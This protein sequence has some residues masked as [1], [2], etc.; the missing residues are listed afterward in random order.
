MMLRSC[1]VGLALVL[2]TGSTAVAQ[3][4]APPPAPS[5]QPPTPSPTPRP[6]EPAAPQTPAEPPRFEDTVVVTAS[7]VEEK[8]VNVAP[9]M[10]VINGDTIQNSVSRSYADLLRLVPGVNV[11]QTAARDISVTS[12]SATGTLATSQLALLDGRTI[13]QDFFGFVMWDF[14]PISLDEIKQIEVI[15]G[16]ASATWGAN[17]LTGVVNVISKS[18][19]ELKGTTVDMRFG[20]FDRSVPGLDQKAGALFSINGT[21][22]DVINDRWAYKI[23]AGGVTQQA[24]PRPTGTI[25]NAFAT[26]YPAYANQGTTQ[27]KFDARVDHDLSGN[28]QL[29][30]AGGVAGTRG[31]IHT[32]IGPFDIQSGS[33]LGYG[34]VNY[35]RGPLKINFF[36][37][38]LDGDADGLL[39]LDTRGQP[40]LFKFKNQ[41][42]DLEFGNVQTVGTRHVINYGGNVRHNTFDLSIAPRGTSRNEG[43]AYAQDEIVLSDHL[44]WIVGGRVDRFDVLSNAV[45][46]PRTTL[47]LKVTPHHTVRVSY[48]R[49][50]RAPSLVNN[51]IDVGI[52]NQIDL[53]LINPALAG[54]N[55]VFPTQAVGNDQLKEESLPA[56]EIGYT[57]VFPRRTIVSAAFYVNDTKNEILFKQIGSYTSAAPA[58]G[59]PLPPSVLDLLVAGNAFGPGAGLPS[60]FSY[61]NFGTIRDKGIELGVESAMHPSTSVFVNY[62]FQAKPVPTGFDISDLNLPPQNRFNAGANF[63]RGHYL[64]NVSVSF[65]DGAFWQD[66]LDARFHGPTDSYT[67]VNGGFGV[68]WNSGKLTTSVGVTNLLNQNVQQHVFGDVLKRQVVGQLRVRF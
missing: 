33:V 60:L 10:T 43:G 66:V 55:Y 57:G 21:H 5:S 54:H 52:L 61:R 25:N 51:F 40:L 3:T 17:A 41:T 59:W 67:L 64:G 13:Y 47:L 49:G 18:P 19:R 45:F 27:P 1:G 36:V 4:P 8:L 42:Y 32:G 34:K 62:S 15:R 23:S 39:S 26:P 24:L 16:P 2:A 14:L 9:T 65:V 56:Y 50:Y 28:Q 31:I 38:V 37:N 46:S 63:S 68:R 22:A 48:N 12:R 7:K 29:I 44:H 35:T 6:A 58:P 30:F 53:G 11:S 20:T